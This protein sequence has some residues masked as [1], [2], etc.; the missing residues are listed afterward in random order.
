M[1]SNR[2]KY[3]IQTIGIILIVI[4]SSMKL[5]FNYQMPRV[6][7]YSIVVIAGIYFYLTFRN[8]FTS[9]YYQLKN[10]SR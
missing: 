3:Y 2:I 7:S 8:G 5:I 4:N 6:L 10:R 1:K 9:F